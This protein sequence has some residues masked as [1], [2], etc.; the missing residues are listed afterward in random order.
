MYDDNS[1]LDY[2]K[3]ISARSLLEKTDLSIDV[4]ARRLGYDSTEEFEKKFLSI[5]RRKPSSVR[6]NRKK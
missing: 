5:E 4:I 6:R 3:M 1:T 2:I